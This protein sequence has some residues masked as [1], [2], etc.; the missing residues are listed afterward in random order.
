M[1]Q[2][3]GCADTHGEVKYN[4]WEKPTEISKWKEEHVS[5]CSKQGCKTLARRGWHCVITE[6]L[7]Q[8]AVSLLSAPSQ[9]QIVFLVLG[10]WGVGIWSATKV[11]GGKKEAPVAAAAQ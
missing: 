4:A 3:F 9:L 11:F 5:R 8:N 7:Y 6:P 10:C 2:C 1:F